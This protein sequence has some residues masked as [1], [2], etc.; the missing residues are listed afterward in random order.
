MNAEFVETVS[1]IGLGYIGFPTAMILAD[2]GYTVNGADTSEQVIS[3]LSKGEAHLGEAGF[4]ELFAKVHAT[5]KFN[6]TKKYLKS[7]VHLVTVPTPVSETGAP[8][9][10]HVL[11]A[12][13]D[14]CEVLEKGNLLLLE[15]T[16]PVGTTLQL[17]EMIK[18]RRP[19]LKLPHDNQN[20]ADIAIAYC[21]ERVL[22]GNTL[23]ELVANDRI[24]GGI[25]V[26]CTQRARLFYES[27][28]EGRCYST[29]SK[30]AEMVKLAENSFRDV[31]IAFANE[32]SLLADEQAVDVVDLINLANKHPRV[33][34]LQP[35]TGVG[36]HCI[37]VDPWFLINQSPD[38]S[39]LMRCA[40]DVNIAKPNWVVKKILSE[41]EEFTI[42]YKR[43][44]SVACLGLTF[45]PDIDDLRGSPAI[46]VVKNL[47]NHEIDLCVVE[48]HIS[49]E[50]EFNLVTLDKAMSTADIMVILVG[51]SVFRQVHTT[52]KVLDFTGVTKQR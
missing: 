38:T 37:A 43:R 7:D 8:N 31:N 50:T 13:G 1:I 27:F 14:L 18:Q 34:I 35:G 47:L 39:R 48:P 41:L 25:S 33:N 6:V 21:P 30:T 52:K 10:T 17:S 4:D 20:N 9:L 22:P 32:L 51:H 2:N 19:D 16:C 23:H 12:V 15:S 49:F 44:P 36:G 28:V 26:N 40:R 3:L 5:K 29:D 46:E 24:I 45:K 11:A 42:R